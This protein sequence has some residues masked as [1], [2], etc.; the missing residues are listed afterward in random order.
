MLE[1]VTGAGHLL[2]ALE[3][4][5]ERDRRVAILGTPTVHGR[6]D[7]AQHFFVSGYLVAMVGTEAAHTAG[8]A[9]ELMDAHSASG[10][11]FADI[12]AD[13]AGVQFAERI[14]SKRIKLSSIAQRF[15]VSDFV[16]DVKQLTEGLTAVE[17]ASKFGAVTDPRFQKQLKAIDQRVLLLPPY[18][19]PMRLNVP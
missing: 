2:Q 18:R 10:F 16:P 3:D 11:S 5:S 15:V 7:L 17:V 4:S 9:K 13:R 14:L 8:I 19:L 1:T 6:Y 12:A